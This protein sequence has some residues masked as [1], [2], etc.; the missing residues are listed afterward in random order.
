MPTGSLGIFHVPEALTQHQD[1]LP[2]VS[3]DIQKHFAFVTVSASG[4]VCIK[5]AQ[6]A[7]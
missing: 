5:G 7:L 6:P 1:P 3:S 4:C 2:T